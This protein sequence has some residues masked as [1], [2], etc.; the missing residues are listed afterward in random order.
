MDM[1]W[2]FWFVLFI[3]EEVIIRKERK[4]A[5]AAANLLCACIEET[6]F[7]PCN[8]NLHILLLEIIMYA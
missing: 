6:L 2:L 5:K 3:G 7:P 4:S 8:I 1:A